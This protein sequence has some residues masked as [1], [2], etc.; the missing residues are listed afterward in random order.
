MLNELQELSKAE[1]VLAVVRSPEESMQ[2]ESVGQAVIA[3]A[4]EEQ[5]FEALVAGWKFYIKAHRKTTELLMPEITHGDHGLQNRGDIDV[6][7][8]IMPVLADY[9]LNKKQWSR[10]REIFAIPEESL[11]GYIDECIEKSSEPTKAGL[12]KNVNRLALFMSDSIE[13]YTPAVYVE[14]ARNVM[15]AIDV[16]PAS[17]A[18]A[19]AI[20]KAGT[21][22][23]IETNGLE[24][25][26][27]GRVFMNPPYGKLAP[28]FVDKLLDQYS[29]G[30]TTEAVVLLNLHG[31]SAGWFEPLWDHMLCFVKGRIGF[32]THSEG[33]QGGNPIGSVFIYLGDGLKYFADEF[34]QHGYIV[35]RW[36]C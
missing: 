7:S 29:R 2:L 36:P 16:D 3:W 27:P 22:Y 6:P 21:Y 11:F 10:R 35:R 4:R 24:H 8:V 25:D 30:I 13:W 1:Q 17:C 28:K 33:P 32:Y 31:V 18:E 5:R 9:G 20:V 12:L 34:N 23:T 19:N 14:S 26:W 15:G